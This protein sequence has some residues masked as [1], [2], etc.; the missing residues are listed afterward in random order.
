MGASDALPQ[1][2][3]DSSKLDAAALLARRQDWLDERKPSEEGLKLV[4]ENIGWGMVV[5]SPRSKGAWH[6]ILTHLDTDHRASVARGIGMGLGA[7]GKNGCLTLR[8]LGGPDREAITEGF[9]EIR[10]VAS[11]DPS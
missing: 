11:C 6:A 10:P 9:E 5:F 3:H 8:D 7:A 4:H 1:D 2:T